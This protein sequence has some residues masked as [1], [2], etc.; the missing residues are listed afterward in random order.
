MKTLTAKKRLIA[1]VDKLLDETII[2]PEI[3]LSFCNPFNRYADL[4]FEVTVS[5]SFYS[6]GY[7]ENERIF[8]SC[9]TVNVTKFDMLDENSDKVL[10][11]SQES[12]LVRY[13]SQYISDYYDNKGKRHI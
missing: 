9:S 11:N 7:D 2:E 4:D 10:S 13:I 5:L 3:N 6:D 8:F 12:E 1:I